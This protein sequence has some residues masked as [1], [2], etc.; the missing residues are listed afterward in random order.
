MKG[1]FEK[2]DEVYS[3]D[4]CSL[5]EEMLNIDTNKRPDLN[6]ILEKPFMLKYI[7]LNLIRQLSNSK[8]TRYTPN[9]FFSEESFKFDKIQIKEDSCNLNLNF[10][11]ALSPSQISVDSNKVSF[12]VSDEL[13]VYK[14]ASSSSSKNS[15]ERFSHN[16]KKSE[17]NENAVVEQTYDKNSVFTKIEKLKKFL[18]KFLGL[19]TFLEIYFK[20]N[21]SYK[22]ILGILFK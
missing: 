6:T 12:T 21:V 8:N 5:V 16:K 13:N 17:K 3:K 9:N 4:L 15:S 14:I 11:S 10:I 19:E 1:E 18:E 2:V 7:K 22:F 20:I